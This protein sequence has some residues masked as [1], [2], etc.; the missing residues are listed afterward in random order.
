MRKRIDNGNLKRKTE[1]SDKIGARESLKIKEKEKNGYGVWFGLGAIGIVGWSVVASTLMG[2]A[3]GLWMD[4]NMHS[5]HSWTLT[6]LVVGIF[7][8]CLNAW[9]W[10]EKEDRAMHKDVPTKKEASKSEDQE[11]K[12]E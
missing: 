1:L 10:I 4:K 9:H 7:I 6:F 12:D 5:S 8:G 3:L 2:I 11:D